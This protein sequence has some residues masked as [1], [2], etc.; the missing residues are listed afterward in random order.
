M[1]IVVVLNSLGMGGAEKQALAV[2]EEMVNRGH[3]VALLVL[4][5]RLPAEW[6]TSLQSVSLGMSKSPASFAAALL[7]ARRFL[8]EFEPDLL[9]SHSFHPNIFA[10]LLKL[11][12]PSVQVVSTVH[13]VYEGGSTRMLLYRL[14]DTLARRTVFVSRAAAD[15]F[16]RLRAVSQS[17]C[18]VLP[19]G[20]DV[21]EFAPDPMRRAAARS[22]LSAGSRFVWFTAG[23]LVTAKDL[24]N[25]LDAFCQVLRRFPDTE[26][27]IAG[28]PANAKGIRHSDGK[29]SL[30]W[31]SAM[32]H[33]MADR[34]RWL[35]LRRD[36]PALLDAAD[37][38]VLASAWEG[39]PL[40]LGEAM[41]MEKPVVVTDV[42]GVRELLGDAG[43]V[44]EAKNP[45]ALAEAMSATM[46]ESRESLAAYGHR[47][48]SRIQEQFNLAS[49]IEAWQALYFVLKPDHRHE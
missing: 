42:G 20:I 18:V 21:A 14:T 22:A 7:R 41:A 32:E 6:P 30:V 48:R 1:R 12:L 33:G 10:R 49:V 37:A 4:K 46:L 34:V 5:L 27:W 3:Q 24:P 47:A 2:A 45:E 16:T 44:V 39:M 23:R 31:L 13:N 26:L 28:A 19:N 25:L 9:H 29:T 8:R 40:A 38:F 11:A 36:I 35:G 17:R 43:I 15:R